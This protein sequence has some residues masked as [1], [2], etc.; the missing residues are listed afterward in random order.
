MEWPDQPLE[1]LP[2]GDFRP[3]HCPVRD[4][5]SHRSPG[6]FRCH[7]HGAYVRKGDGRTVTRYC[8]LTCETTF[9]VQT[10]SVTYYLKR[11]E[12]V[13]PIAAGLNAGSAHRQL[14]RSLGC[15][16]STVTL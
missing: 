4:C 11:P 10:F 14:A 6:S 12:L 9:S 5:R 8:C 13:V 3:E 16:P 7:R 15:A 2:P 1:S